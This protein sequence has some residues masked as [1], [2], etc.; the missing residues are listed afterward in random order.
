M[1]RQNILDISGALA[2]AKLD[3]VA[4]P[5]T[6]IVAASDSKNKAGAHFVCDGVDDQEEIQAAIDEAFEKYSEEQMDF[7]HYCEPSSLLL[8]PGTYHITDTIDIS[9][10]NDIVIIGY[11]AVLAWEGADNGLMI[12]L[13]CSSRA[14]IYGLR[15]DGN[16]K[17]GTLIHH[18]GNGTSNNDPPPGGNLKGKGCVSYNVY[19]DVLFEKQYPSAT[20]G[21]LD[22]APYTSDIDP[23]KAYYYSMDD[24]AFYHCIFRSGYGAFAINLSAIEVIF[25]HPIFITPNGIR[26]KWGYGA[27]FALF[28]PVFS[29]QGGSYGAIYAETEDGGTRGVHISK[30]DLYSPYYEENA[31]AAL[32]KYDSTA[33]S[34]SVKALNIYGGV[35]SQTT[36][37]TNLIEIPSGIWGK[38]FIQNPRLIKPDGGQISAPNCRIELNQLPT[39]AGYDDHP[40]TIAAGR[41]LKRSGSATIPAGNTAV[42][43]SHG[44]GAAPS[45]VL[46]TPRGNVGSVWVTNVTSTQFTINCSSA[47]SSDTQVDWYAEV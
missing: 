9:F 19:R 25:F 13:K 47:P 1:P 46:V 22:T 39:A 28:S 21:M 3:V 6:V 38:I 36:G 5:A 4:P 34:G 29:M 2:A 35:L 10:R 26:L 32:F 41:V 7:F 20:G 14:K 45:R 31:P 27:N 44:M 18:S 11:G 30:I 43:V 12:E 33:T 37:A 15:L 17:A 8:L 23:I 24:S 42:T 40:I 16:Y